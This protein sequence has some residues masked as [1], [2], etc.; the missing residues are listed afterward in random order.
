MKVR[1]ITDIELKF[2]VVAMK[3]KLR[4]TEPEDESL[5]DDMIKTV[6]EI[7]VPKIVF[8]EAYVTERFENSVS[9]D[10]EHWKDGSPMKGY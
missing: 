4:I 1:T 9:I 3:A 10:D 2:N 7:A 5:F 8:G 6:L